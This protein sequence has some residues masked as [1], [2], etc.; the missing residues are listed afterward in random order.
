MSDSNTVE[1]NGCMMTFEAYSNY[2]FKDK[3]GKEFRVM[4]NPDNFSRTLSFTYKENKSTNSSKSVGVHNKTGVETFSFTLLLD[5]T[6][7]VDPKRK[8]VK[9]EIEEF[10]DVLF[11]KTKKGGLIPNPIELVYCGETFHCV[12]TSIQ[13]NYT[14][15]KMDGSPL[16][17]KITCGF[18]SCSVIS[19]EEQR[20][21]NEKKKKSKNKCSAESPKELVGNAERN[22]DNS[23]MSK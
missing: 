22:D 16:R 19:E 2:T 5:G 3:L 17:V 11:T 4:I 8:D 21:L 14:L 23:L 13:Y 10:E 12:S 7:V 1:E 6:G 9:G 15:F 20:K 18:S